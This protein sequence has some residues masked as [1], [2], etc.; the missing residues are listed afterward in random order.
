[1]ITRFSPIIPDV[2]AFVASGLD[3]SRAVYRRR[4]TKN[5]DV[6]GAGFRGGG[7]VGTGGR[8]GSASAGFERSPLHC[9]LVVVAVVVVVV[10]VRGS[11]W[12][13]RCCRSEIFPRPGVVCRVG[14]RI[15]RMEFWCVVSIKKG[16]EEYATKKV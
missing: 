10:L 7:G 11:G 15:A 14:Q 12:P 16:R 1:M 13:I 2:I 3:S 4:Y 5:N 8:D 6:S 9:R